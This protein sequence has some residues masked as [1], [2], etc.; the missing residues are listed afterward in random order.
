MTLAVMNFH[1]AAV[2]RALSL[3]LKKSEDRR[4][5]ADKIACQLE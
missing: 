2:H 3:R 5:T 4:A 1:A